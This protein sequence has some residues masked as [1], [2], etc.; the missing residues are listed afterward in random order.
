MPIIFMNIPKYENSNGLEISMKLKR[1]KIAR[2][3]AI[4]TVNLVKK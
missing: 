2:R 1:N 4:N 3:Q